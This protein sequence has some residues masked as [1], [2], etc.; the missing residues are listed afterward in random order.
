V[1]GS[2]ISA[3]GRAKLIDRAVAMARLAPE[4][5]YAASPRPSA[6]RAVRSATWT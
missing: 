4:D 5:P 3:E 6:W 1:S 2:D